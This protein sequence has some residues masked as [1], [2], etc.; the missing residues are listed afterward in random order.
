MPTIPVAIHRTTGQLTEVVEHEPEPRLWTSFD[1][2]LVLGKMH[3][4]ISDQG[5]RKVPA[6]I[7]QQG[8]STFLEIESE[9]GSA[10]VTCTVQGVPEDTTADALRRRL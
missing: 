4:F 10:R 3:W 2:W 7:D 6:R 5:N 1:L 8:S 9:N